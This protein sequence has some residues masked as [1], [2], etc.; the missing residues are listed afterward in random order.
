MRPPATL[1]GTA[2]VPRTRGAAFL[3]ADGLLARWLGMIVLSSS[4]YSL[5]SLTS[6]GRAI[7][8]DVTLSNRRA[9]AEIEV[10]A[11]PL[12]RRR[13]CGVAEEDRFLAGGTR[14]GVPG[15]CSAIGVTKPLMVG[16]I[17]SLIPPGSLNG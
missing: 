17:S 2:V 6:V 7:H 11:A 5:R 10:A 3:L 13:F 9:A 16:A 12:Q 15:S 4:D 14:G 8:H 1:S